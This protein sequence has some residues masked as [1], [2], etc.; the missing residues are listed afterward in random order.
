V[1]RIALHP[2]KNSDYSLHPDLAQG[3]LM[4]LCVIPVTCH[5]FKKEWANNKQTKM[6]SDLIGNP[7]KN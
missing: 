4:F 1:Y 2:G 5:F 6:L 3:K 7:F